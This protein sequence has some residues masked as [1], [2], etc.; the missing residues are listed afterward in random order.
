MDHNTVIRDK[1]TEKYL[2]SEL[3]PKVRDEFEEHYF[4]C[5]E[6]ARDIRA[7]SEF[8]EQSKVVLEEKV[9]WAP[10]AATQGWRAWFRPALVVPVFAMLVAVIAYQHFVTPPQ[11]LQA[12]KKPQ[13][14]PAATVNLLTYGSNAAPLT[15]RASEG[16]LLNIIIP[17]D[18]R[19]TSYQVDLYNPA[20]TLDSS[21]PVPASASNEDTWPIRFPGASRQSG[22]YKL[23]VHGTNTN[24]QD[25]E[26]GSK[27]FELQIQK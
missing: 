25:V 15:A 10:M 23:K 20:G 6:C 21:V 3:E 5:P 24:G 8:V 19:Y 16:F 22:T 14:L 12:E 7:A 4:D 2:L 18:H 26:V 11:A 9:A 27:A 13:I 17:P 1:I